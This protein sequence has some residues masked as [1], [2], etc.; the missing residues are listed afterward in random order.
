MAAF[1]AEE[2]GRAVRKQAAR[3]EAL[4]ERLSKVVGP[5]ENYGEMSTPELA[6][7]GLEKLGMEVPDAGDDPAV[8]ALEFALRGRGREMGTGMDG[9]PPTFLD[10][11]LEA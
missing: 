4:H 2:I 7:Y 9:A 3:H 1:D 11:Y 5:V 6:A 8:V 10:K